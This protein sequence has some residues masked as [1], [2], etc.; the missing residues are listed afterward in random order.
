MAGALNRLFAKVDM[1]EGNPA[2]KIVQF[3]LP[4]LVGNLAQQMYNTVDSIIVGKYVGDDAL[5]AVGSAS[6]ILNLLFVLF[7]GISVGIGIIVAQYYGA[8]DRENLSLSIGTSIT[9]TLLSS[10][11]VMVLAVFVTRPLLRLLNT[12]DETMEWCYQYLMIFF[13]GIAGCAFYNIL[14]GILRGFGDSVSALVY[15]LIAT[16]LNIVLDYSFV[17]FLNMEVAGVAL[18]TVIAQTFSAVLCYRKLRSM[19]D[20]FDSDIRYLKPSAI[21]TKMIIRLGIPS[22]MTQAI[23]SMAMLLVQRLTNSFGTVFIAANVIVMRVDGFAMMPNFS[24][25]TAMTT[26]AGQNIG[27]RQP[28]RVR[29]GT[30]QGLLM[31][32]GTSAVLTGA[33]LIFGKALMGIFT[34]TEE[35]V[36]LS[37][38]IMGILAVGYIAMAVTQ[39]LS[40]VM[41]GAGDTMTPMWISIVTTVIIRV[42]LAYIM[43][44][45]MKKSSMEE[46]APGVPGAALALPL[47]LLISWVVGAV[48]TAVLYRIGNWKKKAIV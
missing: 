36:D 25:G 6:P 2:K 20:Q 17:K 21:H 13:I 32:V 7:V 31:A 23:F 39:T 34:N 10:L 35:L 4:M 45:L 42:P 5:S 15:L 38:R 33:I 12:P 44:D 19:S 8:R 24:F 41:R 22:G 1:T 27:A 29:Q 16:L 9:L 18:A 43:V 26:F 48:I 14:G 37:R 40:G 46:I 3:T 11:F 30:R 28:E 47:S